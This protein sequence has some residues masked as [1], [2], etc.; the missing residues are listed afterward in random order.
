MDIP[1]IGRNAEYW[2][3][4]DMSQIERN[5]EYWRN[6]ADREAAEIQRIKRETEPH[7]GLAQLERAIDAAQ[8]DGEATGFN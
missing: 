8:T 5:A 3:R 2:R 1:Q 7:Q 6:P 4:M